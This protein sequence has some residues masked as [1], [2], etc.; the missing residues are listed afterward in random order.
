MKTANISKNLNYY[1]VNPYLGISYD[2]EVGSKEWYEAI[3][4]AGY[5]FAYKWINSDNNWMWFAKTNAQAN[6][7]AAQLYASE[8]KYDI[9]FARQY[10]SECVDV[11]SLDEYIS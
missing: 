2:I 10:Y 3:K 8:K 7:G 9:K 1:D 6:E 4:K 11:Y 5:K